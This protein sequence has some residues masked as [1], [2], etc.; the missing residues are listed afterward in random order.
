MERNN[1]KIILLFVLTAAFIL[2]GIIG[3]TI[4]YFTSSVDFENEFETALYQID[5][6]EEFVSPDNWLPGDTIPKTVEVEN[7]GNID[8]KVKVCISEEWVSDNGDTL[9][10]KIN[11]ERTTILNL[12]NT[13]KWTKSGGCYIYNE[14]LEPGDTAPTFIESVTFNE[15][16]EASIDCVPVTNNGTTTIE[17]NSTGDGYDNAT[18]KLTF[19]IKTMQDDAAE[20][21]WG[22]NF[23]F[24]N[25]QNENAFT[26]GDEVSIGSE[27][28]YVIKSDT[29]KTT[30]LSKYDLAVGYN[31][32]SSTSC[33]D[34]THNRVSIYED[35]IGKISEMINRDTIGYGLQDEE[36]GT[37]EDSSSGKPCTMIGSVPF[38]SYKYWDDEKYTYIYDKNLSSDPL[39]LSMDNEYTIAYY[40]ENYV[41][42]LKEITDLSVEG[43]L[44]S[45]EDATYL[46]CY[47][48]GSNNLLC[49][50]A[51]NWLFTRS[52]WTGFS[53]FYPNSATPQVCYFSQSHNVFSARYNSYD[54]GVG[55]RPV[56]EIPTSELN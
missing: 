30:L 21:L 12:T 42:E 41:K 25:R 26:A 15:D 47:L 49:S 18:Y 9:P 10:N 2:I 13:D 52:Y 27:H 46:G 32:Y 6:V 16:V 33:V 44:L 4:A 50:S 8:A 22:T 11:G 29:E 40:V 54:Y 45:V 51:P 14:I 55:V 31:H 3:F 38:S 35:N 23:E 48:N 36:V 1:K 19:T 5:T 34:E 39:V 56:I 43:R 37:L 7:T 28:F 24:V 20:Q 53:C 17:C